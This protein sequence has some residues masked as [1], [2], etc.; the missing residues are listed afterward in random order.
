MTPAKIKMA[1]CHHVP[2][3][4]TCMLVILVGAAIPNVV[5]AQ[6]PAELFPH[7][8]GDR[9]DY[10]TFN[11][12]GITTLRVTR[13][14]IAGNGDTF[15]EY[16]NAGGWQYKIDTLFQI[17]TVVAFS[18]TLMYKLS[19]D[20]GDI[21]ST[22]WSPAYAWVERMDTEIVF[23]KARLT[24]VFRFSEAHRDS[25][26]ESMWVYERH[27]SQGVGMVWEEAE[28]SQVTFL[29]GCVIAG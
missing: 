24:K 12:P 23:G 6:S 17:F 19:A 21:W 1:E 9:W 16:N 29:L 28:P 4:S 8:V 10:E 20:T 18:P 11:M 25:G 22:G 26:G 15:I 7:H 14:S 5:L 3:L 27:F 2:T 13:D